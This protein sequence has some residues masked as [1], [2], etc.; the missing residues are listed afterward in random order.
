MSELEKAQNELDRIAKSYIK[1]S[2]LEPITKAD[3]AT[4]LAKATATPEGA[5]L[6]RRIIDLERAS[7]ALGVEL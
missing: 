7:A 1:K 4:A 5:K 6:A 3:K 2:A